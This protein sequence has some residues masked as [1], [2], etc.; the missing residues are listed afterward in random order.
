MLMG[1]HSARRQSIQER[2]RNVYDGILVMPFLNI[3]M[4]TFVIVKFAVKD[5][6]AFSQSAGVSRV[7]QVSNGST[8]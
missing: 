4:S 3:E 6:L 8:T 1:N 2:K 5:A 7:S